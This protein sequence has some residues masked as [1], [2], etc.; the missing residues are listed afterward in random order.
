MNIFFSVSNNYVNYLAVTVLSILE[1]NKNSTICF[2]IL[3][4]DRS[5]NSKFILSTLVSKHDDASIEFVYINKDSFADLKL[6]IK[7]ITIEGYYRYVIPNLFANIDRCIYLDADLVVTDSLKAFY[8]I[9]IKDNYCAAINDLYIQEIGY[10]NKIDIMHTY[11]NS[12][13]L[14]MNLSKMR[15]DNI[16]EKFFLNSKLYKDRIQFQDQDIINI[17]LKGKVKELNSIYNFASTNIAH[18]KHKRHK[19]IIIHYTGPVKPWNIKCKN[20]LRY[21]WRHYNES[22]NYF[23]QTNNIH[24]DLPLQKFSFLSE[25]LDRVRYHCNK[26]LNDGLLKRILSILIRF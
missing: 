17:T 16:V 13:V 21:I 14:L 1:N 12:G 22:Y 25:K 7:Y 18:E 8:D 6:N 9:D 19:A 20:H 23:I 2:Y 5:D 4:S 11:V 26:R 10:S 3:T 15:K 24:T